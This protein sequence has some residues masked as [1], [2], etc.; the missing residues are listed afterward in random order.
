MKLLR[1]IVKSYLSNLGKCKPVEFVDGNGRRLWRVHRKSIIF[2]HAL[3]DE[4]RV[5]KTAEFEARY[6]AEKF[7]E[8]LLNKERSEVRVR[9]PE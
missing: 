4:G 5:D 1:T 6:E 3:N 2:W 9:V 8:R 7:I